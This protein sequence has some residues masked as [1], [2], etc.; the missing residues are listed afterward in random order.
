MNLQVSY[1]IGCGVR[2]SRLILESQK[3]ITDAPLLPAVRIRPRCN[4]SSLVRTGERAKS[5]CVS[6]SDSQTSRKDRQRD[7]VLALRPASY[8]FSQTFSHLNEHKLSVEIVLT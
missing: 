8:G 5:V 7:L 3:L 4:M 2:Q 1:V 6:Q